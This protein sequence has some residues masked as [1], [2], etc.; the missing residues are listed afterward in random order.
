MQRHAI[1][2]SQFGHD[3]VPRQTAFDGPPIPQ[4]AVAAGQPALGTVA[5]RLWQKA[6]AV[7]FTSAANRP[8]LAFSP[9][10]GFSRLAPDRSIPPDL[11]FSLKKVAGIKPSFRHNSAVGNGFS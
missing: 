3:P 9:S 4:P 11:A 8:S 6:H 2:G 7:A 1:H 5:L 10:S